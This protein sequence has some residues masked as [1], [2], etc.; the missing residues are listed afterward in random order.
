M[1]CYVGISNDSLS[2]FDVQ[3]HGC[4]GNFAEYRKVLS[5]LQDRGLVLDNYCRYQRILFPETIS[6]QHIWPPMDLEWE[7]SSSSFNIGY[8]INRTFHY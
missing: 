7:V 8:N 5:E 2:L 3:H 1:F 4:I 6:I